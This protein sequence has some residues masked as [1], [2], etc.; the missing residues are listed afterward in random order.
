MKIHLNQPQ[1]FHELGRRDNNE[2]CI[3]P[4]LN[5]ATS[6]D[7]VFIVCDG[8]G[9]ASKGEE[10]SRLVCETLAACFSDPNA[11]ADEAA[12]IQAV[13]LAEKAIDGYL[14]DHPSG[15]GMGT[16][17]TFLQLHAQGATIAHVGDSR[18]Y[19]IRK[20]S[21]LFKT[22]DHS[23]MN[24]LI[25]NGI[26]TV[27][28]AQHHPQRNVI[29]RAIQSS[30]RHVQPD[31][32]LITDVQAGD[33]FFL[34]TDGVLEQ[35]SETTLCKTL[36]DPHATDAPKMA[37]LKSVC[38]GQTRDNFSAILVSVATVD[39]PN[40]PAERAVWE[41]S[42]EEPVVAATFEPAPVPPKPLEQAI[43]TSLSRPVPV[44]KTPVAVA[45]PAPVQTN[46]ATKQQKGLIIAL[47]VAAVVFM[48]LG[49][50]WNDWF[51]KKERK[52]STNTQPEKHNYK[53]DKPVAPNPAKIEPTSPAKSVEKADSKGVLKD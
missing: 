36:A 20:G 49:Y 1:S 51:G 40:P 22:D 10:A 23:L 42:A 21:I 7:T 15:K 31:V 9:G 50:N 39:D 48:T 37:T 41:G 35:L 47:V 44:V 29:T 18:V 12:L 6:N 53:S 2:D 30:Q 26:L 38:F 16:T 27:A 13:S 45:P 11:M 17:M 52:S 34:C 33:F 46:A 5:Q 19:Q 24:D 43:P 25:R 4:K 8:V 28:Q 32:H 3:F 14:L